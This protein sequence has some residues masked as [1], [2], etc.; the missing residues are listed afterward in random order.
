MTSLLYV[1]ASMIINIKAI[2]AKGCPLMKILTITLGLLLSVSLH[3]ETE[4][5]KEIPSKEDQG[6]IVTT[7]KK[8]SGETKRML[9]IVGRKSMDESCELTNSKD[10]CDKQKAEHAAMNKKDEIEGVDGN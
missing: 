7:A 8:V 2:N 9:R 3:A 4:T 1:I 5:K 10:F 6:K